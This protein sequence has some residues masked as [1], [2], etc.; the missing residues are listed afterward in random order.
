MVSFTLNSLILSVSLA[1]ATIVTL[2]SAASAASIHRGTAPSDPCARLGSKNGRNIKYKDVAACY[3]A[4]PIDRDRAATTISTVHHLFRGYYVF[5]DSALTPQVPA[6][7]ASEP[8]NILK[9]L[10]TIGRHNYTSDYQFHTDIRHAVDT[11]RDGHA[12]YDVNCYTNYGFEQNLSLYA[13]VENDIQTLRVFKD[14]ANR[15]Y[16]DCIVDKIDGNPGLAH[17]R[18]WAAKRVSCSHDVNVR[19]NCALARQGYDV[20]KAAY[21]DEP[22]EFSYQSYLPERGY[23]NYEL[24]CSNKRSSSPIRLR[25]EWN[26]YPQS[27]IAFKDIKSYVTNVCLKEESE[28]ESTSQ[29][30]SR[31]HRRNLAIPIMKRD[32]EDDNTLAGAVGAPRRV[33]E[34]RD[35]EKLVSGNA[36]VFYHLKTQPDTGIMVVH[37]FDAQDTEVNTVLKGLTAFNTRKVTKILVDFQGNGGGLISLSSNLVQMLFPNKQPRDASY[38]AD[39]RVTKS[40]QRAAAVGF[41]TDDGGYQIYNANGYYDL[42][43]AGPARPYNNNNLFTKPINITRNGRTTLYSEKTAM[44]FDPLSKKILNAIAK[45]PWTGHHENIRILTDGRCGSA[46]GMASYFW[47]T[48][49]G[50]KAYSIGGT[51]GEDLSMFSFAGASVITL[52]DVHDT[53]NGL[54]LTSPLEDLAYKNEVR[55]S[56]LE[57][58]G[59]NRTTPLEY[60]AELY[61]PKHRLDYTRENAR[62]REVM[63]KEVVAA[64]WKK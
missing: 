42:Q 30:R 9:K 51:K 38:E 58:Y 37:T 14:N 21:L 26:V 43:A 48:T 62:S 44:Y 60:D 45:F 41:K 24:R 29:G 22:G 33:Q 53:Y 64:A 56:W 40:V 34:F 20:K 10:T 31:P 17:I 59:K 12:S 61:R 47:T 63:W 16:E 28:P 36:T 19:Q 32:L 18:A 11:L 46:C 39:L 23:V 27:E 13:P 50:V 6:P 4:I 1:A 52:K 5:T 25:E 35:A 7:F 2:S 3:Q 8:V 15:G 57:L 55:F 49:H 54:N